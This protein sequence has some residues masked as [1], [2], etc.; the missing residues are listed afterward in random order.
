MLFSV[1]SLFRCYNGTVTHVEK[2]RGR[3]MWVH[4]RE[5]S[6]FTLQAFGTNLN[7]TDPGTGVPAQ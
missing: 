5:N 4:D 1:V 2:V 3:G 7:G 6:S